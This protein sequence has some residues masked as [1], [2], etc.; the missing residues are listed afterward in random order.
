METLGV[1]SFSSRQFL[2]SFGHRVSTSSG[3]AR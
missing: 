3:E 2:S 1:F